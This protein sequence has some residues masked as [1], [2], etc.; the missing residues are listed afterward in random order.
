[1]LP[2]KVNINSF[3]LCKLKLRDTNLGTNRDQK[4]K[5]H[6]GRSPRVV[7]EGVAGTGKLRHVCPL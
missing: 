7:Q 2:E 1:M 6:D 5:G 3:A 4:H